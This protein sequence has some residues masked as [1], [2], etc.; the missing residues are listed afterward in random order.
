MT[1]PSFLHIPRH[2]ISS[3]SP[4]SQ[5]AAVEWGVVLL[6]C[7]FTLYALA[8]QPTINGS[9]NPYAEDVGEFQNVLTQWGTAHPT[10]YPLYALTGALVTTLLRIVGMAPAMAASAFSLLVMLLALLGVYALLLKVNLKPGLAAGTTVLLGLLFPYWYHAA[11]AEVYALLIALLVL[12]LLIA[13]QW[14]TD[15]KPRHLYELAFVYGLAFGHHRLAVLLAPALL[16]LIWTPL[17]AA[18]RERPLRSVGAVFS[19][20]AAFLIYLY[21]PLRAWMGGTW[22]YGQ[23][24]TWQGFWAIVLAREYGA[25]VKPA[26]NLAQT[27]SSLTTVVKTIAADTTWPVMI[28]GLCGLGL[29][30]TSPVRR[31]L[32]LAL[33]ALLI[34]NIAFAGL[35]ARDVFLPA[36]LMP[37]MLALVV[38]AGLLAQWM[39]ERWRVGA[40]LSV[41]GLLVIIFALIYSNGPM[42]YAMTH[43]DAGQAIIENVREA[44]INKS[45]ERPVVMALWGRDYFS[46][47]YGQQVTGELAGIKMV[48]HRADVKDLIANGQTL[49]VLRPTF[50]LRPLDWWTA[51]LGRA[52]LSSY[53]GDLVR[54]SARPILTDVDVPVNRSVL[55]APG[56]V[57]RDWQVKSLGDGRWHLTLYWQAASP[58][59]QNYSISVKA[60]D[61]DAIDDPTDI[62]AQADSSA[63]VYGWYPMTLW[64]P[65]EIVRDDYV[66]APVSDRSA[67]LVEVSLYTQDSAGQFQ[68]FGRQVIPLPE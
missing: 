7:L 22:I 65:G 14:R 43:D 28:A 57:L 29:S 5:P 20:A 66:I 30:L 54:V 34:L 35:F 6:V 11:V 53:A 19:L 55:M 40:V 39:G 41:A 64:S 32:A 47:V 4:A 52:Y 36:A 50:Y 27:E 16:I 49:Y 62:I 21:L 9:S 1:I 8:L 17:Y 46:L 24:G 44:G 3:G 23:P 59:D 45:A 42:I 26:S 56:I 2:T 18:L 31:W 37:A 33:W 48:D 10:G 58:P 13:L 60:T 61:R 15:R 38:G 67:H 12:S 63:P 51:L 68:N 25:L